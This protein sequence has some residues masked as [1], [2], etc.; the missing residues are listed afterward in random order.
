MEDSRKLEDKDRALF[1]YLFKILKNQGD[2]EYDYD[3]MIKAL[4]YGFCLHYKDVFDC[5]FDEELSEEEC[6][7]VLDILEM[8]RGITYSYINLK[9][10]DKEGELTDEMISFPGFD[11]NNETKQL[12]YVHYFL[13][14]LGRYEEI[15]K[16]SNGYYDSHYPKLGE[17]RRKYKRWQEFTNKYKMTEMEILDIL[18][19][20]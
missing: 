8:Y 4:Q 19:I 2:D 12:S 14:D 15:K 6:K 10:Q 17:Y 7:E 16:Y 1:I 5:L 11:G 13:D 20:L 18:N 9:N 3:N